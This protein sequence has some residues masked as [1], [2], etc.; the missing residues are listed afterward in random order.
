V[1]ALADVDVHGA[2]AQVLD[3]RPGEAWVIR[4]DG[5]IAAIVDTPGL[6]RAAILRLLGDPPPAPHGSSQ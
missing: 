6:V 2:V 3:A 1:L 4:P 5:H